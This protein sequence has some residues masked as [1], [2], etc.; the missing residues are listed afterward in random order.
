MACGYP[1]KNLGDIPDGGFLGGFRANIA[2][3][4]AYQDR[5]K[6]VKIGIPER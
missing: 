3:A 5:K 1:P 6:L 4:I 2:T